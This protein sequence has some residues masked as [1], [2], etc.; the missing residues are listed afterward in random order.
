MREHM[1]NIQKLVSLPSHLA[2][3]AGSAP[4]PNDANTFVAGDPNGHSLG[5]GGSAAFLLAQAWQKTGDQRA[6]PDWL[7]ES[8]KM[9]ICGGGFSKS[10]PA[11]A[12]LAA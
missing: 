8:R 11:Y 5:S 10:L 3:A 2:E 6:F 7:K 9:I 4:I 12:Q 1:S